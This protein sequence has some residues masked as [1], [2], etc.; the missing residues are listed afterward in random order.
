MGDRHYIVDMCRE[1]WPWVSTHASYQ[2]AV[3]AQRRLEPRRSATDK[4]GNRVWRYM[5]ECHY[6]PE[7]CATLHSRSQALEDQAKAA[8]VQ[9]TFI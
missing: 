2:A 3:K 1:G 5:I 4:Q 9:P 8:E 6:G 7:H